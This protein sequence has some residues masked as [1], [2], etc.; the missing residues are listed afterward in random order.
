MGASFIGSLYLLLSDKV[1]FAVGVQ[2]QSKRNY[3]DRQ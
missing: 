1:L 2:I 3:T